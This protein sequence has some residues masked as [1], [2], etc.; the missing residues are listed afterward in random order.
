MLDGYSRG[1]VHWDL[2]EAVQE[3]DLEVILE[4]AKEKHPEAKPRT[5]SDN[6]PQFI[7]RDQGVFSH[8]G[9]DACPNLA[10]LSAVE[11]EAGALAQ[12]GK[13]GMHSGAN[14]AVARRRETPDFNS[15]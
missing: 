5:I 10:L 14:A 15:T 2:R 4:R 9:H 7:A 3:A 1:I 11:R 6:G 8:L 12:V 13:P